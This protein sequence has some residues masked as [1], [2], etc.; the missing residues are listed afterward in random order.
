M[1]RAL[2]LCCA[3]GLL[4]AGEAVSVTTKPMTFTG[5]YQPKRENSHYY[6]KKQ[7]E[8]KKDVTVDVIVLDNGLVEAW[9]VP[10]WGARLLRAIDKKT[11]V[12]YFEWT[13][14]VQFK[15][16]WSRPGGWRTT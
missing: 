15:L 10:V 12:D 13:G 16:A 14:E 9:V 5:L 7:P 1:I 4:A 11:K 6:D 3:F 8:E 2:I